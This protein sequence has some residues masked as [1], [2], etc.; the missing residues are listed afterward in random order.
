M[1]LLSFPSRFSIASIMLVTSIRGFLLH[2]L[3][4]S[5]AAASYRHRQRAASKMGAT[6]QLS[7][8]GLWTA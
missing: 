7:T 3:Q 2:P 5:N 1:L 4:S 6:V 8:D